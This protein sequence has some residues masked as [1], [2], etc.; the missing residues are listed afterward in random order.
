[1]KIQKSRIYII[2]SV[3]MLASVLLGF[4]RTFFLRPFFEQPE[5]W[6]LEQIPWL[7]VVHGIILTAWFVLLL[8]QSLLIRNR[9]VGAHRRLGF[10][11]AGLAV[12]V[13]VSGVQVLRDANPRVV[14]MGVIDPQ[15]LD[16]LRGQLIFIYHDL[17]S[18][19]VFTIAISVA[20]LYRANRLL[21]STMIM[22]G[23]LAFMG[24]TGGRII[25]LIPELSLPMLVLLTSIF[26]FAGPTALLVHDWRALKRFPTYAAVGLGM[27]VLKIAIAIA[28]SGSEIGFTFFMEYLSGIK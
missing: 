23:S 24:A 18:L 27:I 14:A 7:Y 9:N 22:V 28:L 8:V 17:G 4:A 20:L 11:M 25:Q 21:H 3:V 16:T 2:L 12:L 5:R 1:M 15:D 13:V 10:A 6:Q 26:L 19:V